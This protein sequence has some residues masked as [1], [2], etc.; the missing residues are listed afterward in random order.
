MSRAI[1]LLALDNWLLEHVIHLVITFDL[2][3]FS[4]QH[5]KSAWYL[6]SIGYNHHRCILVSSIYPYYYKHMCNKQTMK[7]N[8]SPNGHGHLPLI[9]PWSW[10]WPHP[11]TESYGPCSSCEFVLSAGPLNKGSIVD[12]SRSKAANHIATWSN[13]GCLAS[14]RSY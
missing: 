3:P 13:F 9:W 11:K 4:L 8:Y 1:P 6:L 5:I 7:I 10:T 14:V 12:V 2:F